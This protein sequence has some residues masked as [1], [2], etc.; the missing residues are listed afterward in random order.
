MLFVNLGAPV[1]LAHFFWPLHGS[2]RLPYYCQ[3][4]RLTASLCLSRSHPQCLRLCYSYPRVYFVPFSTIWV[5]KG[6]GFESHAVLLEQ[7]TRI[8]PLNVYTQLHLKQR[9]LG[10]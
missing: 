3:S 8:F 2:S 9:V 6:R 5:N 10:C 7:E 4:E 1:P